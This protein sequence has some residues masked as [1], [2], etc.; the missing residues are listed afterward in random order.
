VALHTTHPLVLTA[1]LV[2]TP[3]LGACRAENEPDKD[4]V[5]VVE[6][7]VANVGTCDALGIVEM[8]ASL[9][10]EFVEGVDCEAGAVAIA[11]VPPGEYT[12]S[13]QGLDQDGFAIVGNDVSDA[14]T[15]ES[16]DTTVTTSVHLAFIPVSLL[17]RWDDPGDS[18]AM[19]GFSRL[20]VRAYGNEG[21]WLLEEDE[22]DCSAPPDDE[23]GY[24][25]FDDPFDYLEGDG[26][27]AVSVNAL[28]DA[29]DEIGNDVV[30]WFDPPGHGRTVKISLTC[31]G[32]G[33]QCASPRG[34]GDCPID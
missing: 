32:L 27:E 5:V 28:D 18:C 23:D 31:D 34:D 11:A 14:V 30:F 10:D 13:L 4:R 25:T 20:R 29:G 16:H 12:V 1:L 8:Q 19:G 7:A 21:A 6:Y 9:G 22:L 15:V 24:R 17:V 2:G 26:L 33:C 3:L